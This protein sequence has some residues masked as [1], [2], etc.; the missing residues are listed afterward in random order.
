MVFDGV[1]FDDWTEGDYGD[2]DWS[3]VCQEHSEKWGGTETVSG[4]LHECPGEPICGVKGCD[5]IAEY[6]IDFPKGKTSER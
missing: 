6:Y 5:N 2:D 3:Q 4:I 1:E